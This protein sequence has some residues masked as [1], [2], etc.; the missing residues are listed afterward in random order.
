MTEFSLFM[1]IVWT[2]LTIICYYFV[3]RKRRFIRKFGGVCLLVLYLACILR[4]LMPLELP[5]LRIVEFKGWMAEA[6]AVIFLDERAF[7][8]F[9]F[10]IAKN[11]I[12]IW[13]CGTGLSAAAWVFRYTR[14]LKKVNLSRCCEEV[15]DEAVMGKVRQAYK[16]KVKVKILRCPAISVPMGIGLVKKKILLP[17]SR[18]GDKESY[19]ILLHEYTHFINR[20]IWI[21]MF[22]QIFCC[23][24]WWNP[25][26]YLLQKEM[27]QALEIKCDLTVTKAMNKEGK[28]SY[29]NTII[30]VLKKT[31]EGKGIS[32][33]IPMTTLFERDREV[34]VKERF[35]VVMDTCVYP[36]H[37]RGLQIVLTI[38]LCLGIFS[39][40][41]FQF[42]PVFQPPEKELPKE[43]EMTGEN[44]YLIDC[45][46]Y[47]MIADE[48]SKTE[49]TIVTEK[50][51]VEDMIEQG[52][53]VIKE[54]EYYDQKE[55]N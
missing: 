26:V 10:T 30:S 36:K 9:T 43:M 41:T 5:F 51:I 33:D 53:K 15:K 22:L 35:E 8:G 50:W 42:Q 44:T 46:T 31:T 24:Y 28:I 23:I 6:Y 14:A 47:F 20:D 29:L 4:L 32:T 37:S 45:G 18:Y 17:M 39:S 48:I 13:G 1:T 19:Y 38:C 11:L 34:P 16:R 12:G 2:G 40:Y 52:F 7:L 27:D 54:G 21:K 49:P 55:E 3:L 25:C